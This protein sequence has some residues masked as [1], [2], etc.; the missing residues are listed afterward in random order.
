MVVAG[1]AFEANWTLREEQIQF[2]NNQAV[3]IDTSHQKRR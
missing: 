3:E 2:T 1:S